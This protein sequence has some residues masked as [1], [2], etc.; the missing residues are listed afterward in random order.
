MSD[1]A[2]SSIPVMRKP[3]DAMSTGLNS[4]NLAAAAMQRHP[5]DRMQRANGGSGS[6]QSPLDLD[7]IRR[8]YGSGLAMS[9]A[10][11]RQMALKVGGRLPGMDAHPDSR[12]MYE[13]L[14]GDDTSIGFGDFL[15]LKRNRPEVGDFGGASEEVPHAAMEARL[16]L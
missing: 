6:T 15:N 1:S 9:L 11:E 12:A 2:M 4:N 8:L 10:T 3:S 14:T 16:G 7:A 13:S 5:I